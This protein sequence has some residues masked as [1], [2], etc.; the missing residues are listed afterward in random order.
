MRQYDMRLLRR[1][2]S[3]MCLIRSTCDSDERARIMVEGMRPIPFARLEIW[4][5]GALILARG[6]DLSARGSGEVWPV[7]RGSA[8]S[9]AA[10]E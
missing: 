8:G 5:D 3:L 10:A 2:G 7:V 6:S 4:R 1:D 9:W